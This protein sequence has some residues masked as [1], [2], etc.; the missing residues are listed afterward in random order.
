MQDTENPVKLFAEQTGMS[1]REIAKITGISQPS[2]SRHIN[3]RQKIGIESE[4][5]YV[6]RLKLSKRKI[7][8]WNE[9][10]Q[11]EQNKKQESPYEE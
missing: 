3:G 9:I 11:T 8:A 7:S 10:I 2:V 1:T 5:R 4:Q 6:R